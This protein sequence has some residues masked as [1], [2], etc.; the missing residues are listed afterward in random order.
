MGTMT[1]LATMV[2]ALTLF[3]QV[4]GAPSPEP[5]FE[6]V[7]IRFETN[8]PEEHYTNFIGGTPPGTDTGANGS[9]DLPLLEQASSSPD[10]AGVEN[11]FSN[12]DVATTSE[13]LSSFSK[14]ELE[15]RRD[16]LLAILDQTSAQISESLSPKLEHVHPLRNVTKTSREETKGEELDTNIVPPQN[17]IP[18]VEYI[19]QQTSQQEEKLVKAVMGSEPKSEKSLALSLNS[20]MILLTIVMLS[21]IHLL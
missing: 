13:D 10:A 2:V 5:K 12:V 21:I 6:Y 9:P 17:E 7:N 4:F 8:T 20:H 16:L 19:P 18:P 3:L 15:S 14:A 1:R 11:P